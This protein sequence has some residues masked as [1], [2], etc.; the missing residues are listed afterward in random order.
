MIIANISDAERYY[1]I[2]PHFRA[3]FNFLK[4]MTEDSTEGI[5]REDYR[6]NF[7]REYRDTADTNPD[8]TQK[9]FETHK[10]YIDIHYC[11][12]GS[13]GMGYADARRLTPIT[14]YN[15]S[16][17]YTFYLGEYQKVILHEGDFCVFFP[18]DAHIQLLKGATDSKVLKAVA[19][20][21]V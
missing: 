7:S 20:I 14:E 5:V 9:V 11:I 2:N 1:D 15:E 8:G 3:V 6:V 21:K 4:G 13:E 10:R 16:G 17:D 12:S 18:E 19:K